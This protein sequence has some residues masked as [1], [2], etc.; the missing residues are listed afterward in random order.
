MIVID[1]D[2]YIKLVPEYPRNSNKG[3]GLFV[4]E[5]LNIYGYISSVGYISF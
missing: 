2:N 1:P 4:S 5:K 3:F